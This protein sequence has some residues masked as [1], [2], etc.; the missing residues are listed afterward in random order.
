M[1]TMTF[2][3]AAQAKYGGRLAPTLYIGPEETA[4]A[5]EIGGTNSRFQLLGRQ[6][7]IGEPF[8]CGT[9]DVSSLR[10]L[11]DQFYDA[12]PDAKKAVAIAVGAA[13]N[14]N[15]HACTLTNGGHLRISAQE[16]EEDMGFRHAIV[17]NDVVAAAKCL[18][19]L[20]ETDMVPVGKETQD[21][22]APRLFL[23][24]GTGFGGATAHF[25]PDTGQW[26][27]HASEIGH[28]PG[29]SLSAD[30]PLRE[31]TDFIDKLGHNGNHNRD[32]STGRG[33]FLL[34][35][36]VLLKNQ[37]CNLSDLM[38]D[39]KVSAKTG[40]P[41]YKDSNPAFILD[42]AKQNDPDA[43]EAIKAFFALLG[44]AAGVQ[45]STHV[46]RGGAYIGG[47]MI[48]RFYEAFAEKDPGFWSEVTQILRAN[49]TDCGPDKFS[50]K[51]PLFLVVNEQ[52]GLIG[53]YNCFK[54]SEDSP[55][56]KLDLRIS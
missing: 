23:T 14:V 31:L 5:A 24:S 12:N 25:S 52:H 56:A 38:K 53:L 44:K 46:A 47:G 42:L 8:F 6:G 36:A 35:T 22:L 26:D 37:R 29:A 41:Q 43:R 3:D 30:D 19:S 17:M 7:P 9:G 4:I 54:A 21:P 33:L 39:A 11:L 48:S 16:L 49:A 51:V 10:D 1:T 45:I 18:G 40:K 13:G 15:N 2:N 55:K 28:V 27:I 50:D 32:R 20:S 34:Y